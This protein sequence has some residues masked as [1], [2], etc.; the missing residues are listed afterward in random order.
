MSSPTCAAG[1]HRAGTRT[2]VVLTVLLAL[3]V[4]LIAAAGPARAHD[5]LLGS[6]PEDGSVQASAPEEI[7]LT[8]S[9]EIA[10]IGAQVVVEGPDGT[11]ADGDP[12]VEGVTV[13]QPVSPDA[14]AGDYSVVWRV[15]SEDGHPISGDF[16][17][18][19]TG[20][21]ETA[22]PEATT[23]PETEGAASDDAAT[24]TSPAGTPGADDAPA[25]ER[26]AATD[27]VVPET[28]GSAG[29][30]TPVWVWVVLGAALL[31]LGGVGAIAVRRR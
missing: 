21:P 1:P 3:L 13:T 9:G 22:E 24:T 17:Y 31:A 15:T 19:V 14:P 2:A 4:T 16:T 27:A 5:V 11:V 28:P 30:G 29:G 10:T 7:V 23:A 25:T 20:D 12:E 18:E 6:S 8:F 26:A